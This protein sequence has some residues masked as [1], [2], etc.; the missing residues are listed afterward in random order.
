MEKAD[1]EKVIETFTKLAVDTDLDP[2]ELAELRQQAKKLSGVGLRVIDSTLK[3]AQEKYNSKRAK[4][5]RSGHTVQRRDPRPHI[6]VPCPD[7][8]WLPVMEGLND[9]IGKSG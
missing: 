5:E 8:P 9:V 2:V 1:K 3:A 6:E 4:E 7:A